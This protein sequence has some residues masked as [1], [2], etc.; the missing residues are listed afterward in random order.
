MNGQPLNGYVLRA[1]ADELQLRS[2]LFGL[3]RR[4]E[5]ANV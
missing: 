4:T 5:T 1:A 3:Q 2:A